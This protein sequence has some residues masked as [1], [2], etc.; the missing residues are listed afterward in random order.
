[1]SDSDGDSVR[2]AHGSP[3]HSPG[4]SPSSPEYEPNGNGEYED[5]DPRL[6]PRNSEYDP[7]NPSYSPM[8]PGGV[9]GPSNPRRS[10]AS[11]SPSP[12]N[13][14]S[15]SPWGNIPSQNSF[16]PGRYD[17]K[18]FDNED[19]KVPIVASGGFELHF[20]DLKY[21]GSKKRKPMEIEKSF[22]LLKKDNSVL[23]FRIKVKESAHGTHLHSFNM[24]LIYLGE[25]SIDCRHSIYIR[26]VSF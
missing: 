12:R 22:G 20:P 8:S 15:P 11:R 3:A 24:E 13:S 6:R 10:R 7:R 25:H 4:Y 18:D 14:R 19:F 1:M 5:P 26:T 17:T 21:Q 2:S 23:K 9:A 16:E